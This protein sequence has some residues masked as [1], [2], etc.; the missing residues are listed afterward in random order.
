MGKNFLFRSG[1]RS[2]NLMIQEFKISNLPFL[3]KF[4]N[5]A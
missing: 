5:V 1:P 3:A 2:I 4:D